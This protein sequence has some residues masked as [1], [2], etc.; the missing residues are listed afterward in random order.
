MLQKP[1]TTWN[2]AEVPGYYSQESYNKVKSY[3][4]YSRRATSKRVV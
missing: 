4:S 2:V 3:K 1:D